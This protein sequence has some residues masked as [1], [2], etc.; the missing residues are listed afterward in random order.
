MKARRQVVLE[1]D[2]FERAILSLAVPDALDNEELARYLQIK[3]LKSEGKS[4]RA[5]GSELKIHA[6][7]VS[8]ILQKVN[9]G[10]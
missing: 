1:N 2:T 8:R 6:S 9:R 10:D 7:T 5:I 3:R 4:L